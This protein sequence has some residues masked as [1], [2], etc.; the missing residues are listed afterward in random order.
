MAEKIRGAKFTFEHHCKSFLPFQSK[1]TKDLL[2]KWCMEESMRTTTFR[3]DQKFSVYEL[4]DFVTD[5]FNDDAV[6][7]NLKILTNVSGGWGT[8]GG[9]SGDTVSVETE[10]VASTA[11]SMEFF[12]RLYDCGAVRKNGDIVGCMP[13][14]LDNGFVINQELGR[15]MLLEDGC[16]EYGIFTP[17]DRRELIFKIFQHLTLGGPINQYDD[18]I[19]PYFNT[20]KEF[21]KSLITVAKDPGT[22]KVHVTSMVAKILAVGGRQDLFPQDG[23]PQNFMYLII[24]PSKRE[25]T[26]WYHAWCG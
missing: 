17:E 6:L 7:Q 25:V 15:V 5:F 16:D 13:E 19:G 2:T 10:P 20:T 4:H 21:Y 8:L 12:D 18:N 11:T 22:R 3:F 14:Y 1:E 9:K 24:N 26:V 23:H